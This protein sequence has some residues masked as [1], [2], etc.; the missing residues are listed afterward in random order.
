M[1]HHKEVIATEHAPKAIGPYN[2]AISTGNLVF[3][4]GQVAFNPATGVLVEGGIRE[5][6]Q[7]TLLN[8]SAILAAVGCT[9]NDAVS[10]TVYVKDMND[11]A[12]MNEVYATFFNEA[13]PSR[14][15]VEVSRLPKDALVEISCIA[16]KP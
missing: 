12:A 4:S 9:P 16:V 10:C 3:V 11:F 5:Q 6:T 2:Q 15:T 14:A 1:S 7:Q 8:L 13:P